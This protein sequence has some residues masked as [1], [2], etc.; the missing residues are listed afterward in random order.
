MIFLSTFRSDKDISFVKRF[1]T[2]SDQDALQK[3][4]FFMVTLQSIVLTA[5]PGTAI[6]V[7]VKDADLDYLSFRMRPQLQGKKKQCHRTKCLGQDSNDLS[8]HSQMAWVL[9]RWTKE[10]AKPRPLENLIL[11]GGKHFLARWFPSL[12]ALTSMPLS[13]LFLCSLLMSD[14][15]VWSMSKIKFLCT[16]AEGLVHTAGISRLLIWLV[17]WHVFVISSWR[18]FRA[19]IK[20][21]LSVQ[22]N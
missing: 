20:M 7:L 2:S 16:G 15:I 1:V 18:H 14:A 13:L 6:C 19:N 21:V 11:K 9:T 4:R 10:Q 12:R 17:I 22:R 3:V 8:N 5:H